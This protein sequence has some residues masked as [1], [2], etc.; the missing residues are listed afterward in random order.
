[1]LVTPLN[2][3][4]FITCPGLKGPGQQSILLHR[5]FR[6]RFGL[7]AHDVFCGESKRL[8]SYLHPRRRF[9][10]TGRNRCA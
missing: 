5:V 6:D 7:W 3:T 2:G 1:M 8:G 4:H 9:P 10:L